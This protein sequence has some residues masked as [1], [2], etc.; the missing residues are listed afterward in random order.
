MT[1][2]RIVETSTDTQ[3]NHRADFKSCPHC[4]HRMEYEQWDKVA[5]TLILA[6]LCWKTN[7]IA[8]MSECPE[9]FKPSWVHH[10][11]DSMDYSDWPESWKERVKRKAAAMRLSALR[12]WAASLCGK[13]A[14]LTSG[15]VDFGTYRH[16]KKGMG[17]STTECDIFTPLPQKPPTP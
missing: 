15:T 12:E 2:K 3:G 1:R 10:T 11:M 6:P 8:V 9:C 7:S 4:G 13:C 5:T 16:C 17:P 14:H